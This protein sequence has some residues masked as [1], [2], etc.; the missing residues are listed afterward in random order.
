MTV[1][2]NS[3]IPHPD[4]QNLQLIDP[5]K[6]DA[7]NAELQSKLNAVVTY[8][9]TMQAAGL[10][11]SAIVLKDITEAQIK[12]FILDDT[13]ATA[14]ANTA[15]VN[16]IFS[17]LVK[18]IKEITGETTWS[19][20][21]D[22]T[23][24]GLAT[25]VADLYTITTSLNNLKAPINN[26]TFTGVVSGV[27]KAMVGLEL[28]D[29]TS[30]VDKPIS[31]AVQVELNTKET[32]AN[33]TTHK[34]SND[35]DSIYIKKTNTDPYVPTDL[36]NPATKEYVDSTVAGVAMGAVPDDS[37][38]DIKLA[39]DVKVGSLATLTTTN[40]TSVTSAIN[41]VN[42][43]P[44]TPADG[45]ITDAKMASDVKVGSLAALTT[46]IKTSIQ[47]AINEINTKPASPIVKCTNLSANDSYTATIPGVTSYVDGDMYSMYTTVANTGPCSLN[48]N[49][50]GAVTINRV[51]NG[52]Y[53]GSTTGDILVNTHNIFVY[54]ATLL[55]FIHINP[56]G[57][58]VDAISTQTLTNKTLSAPKITSSSSIND[59]SGNELIK[60]PA[61][62]ASAV[63]E[64]TITN[65]VTGVAPSI[66]ASGNDTNININNVPKG[67]GRFQES[68][69]NLARFKNATG[70]SFSSGTTTFTITDA[71]VTA[72]TLITVSPI[73]I[74]KGVWSVSSAAGSFVI[75]STVAE[76]IAVSFDWAG[77]K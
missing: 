21:A 69:E 13:I 50:L 48:I 28:V 8:L 51:T 4:F 70:V 73:G 19:A 24:M 74:P 20:T 12:D 37:V 49:G 53:A 35:H 58:L 15:D 76:T 1:L 25:K 6:F 2:V 52:V 30:D 64:I 59:S 56:T 42:A 67:T 5:D 57:V 36:Y 72:N 3:N 44:T 61:T 31:T 43:K 45:T 17:Y 41:E 16:V 14:Y 40:K 68:G 32:I 55:K 75:T 66:S 10:P 77:V 33:L 65:A 60:F 34:T 29:N 63:N 18:R 9:N 71:W 62:V 47:A 23:I 27:T 26:P 22:D 7:N 39:P 46:T 38:G 11:A 54:H